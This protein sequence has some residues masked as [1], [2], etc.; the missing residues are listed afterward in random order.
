M[1]ELHSSV[2]ALSTCGDRWLLEVE[3]ILC[4]V[5][6]LASCLVQG[7]ASSRSPD[8]E[9]P[10]P[11][12]SCFTFPIKTTHMCRWQSQVC[13]LGPE[14]PTDVFE[15]K[16]DLEDH[17]FQDSPTGTKWTTQAPWRR[18]SSGCGLGPGRMHR[19]GDRIGRIC[20]LMYTGGRRGREE[21][22]KMPRSL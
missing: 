6:H 13:Q 4:T 16:D 21:P 15:L 5:G 3:A 20:Q 22:W 10:P 7:L 19:L 18:P 1:L 2:S 11:P 9:N 12:G 8:I 14:R 17:S